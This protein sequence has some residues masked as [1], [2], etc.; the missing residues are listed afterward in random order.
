MCVSV[1]KR[2][3]HIKNEKQ[4]A[5]S[6]AKEKSF[7]N[8]RIYTNILR[9]SYV[10]SIPFHNNCGDKLLPFIVLDV[11]YDDQS[12][13]LQKPIHNSNLYSLNQNI[14]QGN[15]VSV[16]PPSQLSTISG[17]TTYLK[18]SQTLP[19]IRETSAER[20]PTPESQISFKP[21]S[22]KIPKNPTMLQLKRSK[23]S[24]TKQLK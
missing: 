3:N 22:P 11:G 6:E 1:S 19:Q 7:K 12:R 4:L 10:T 15:E 14:I 8:I 23:H 5:I 2:S 17:K 16:I 13:R 9:Q 18:P 24:S 20:L 21:G